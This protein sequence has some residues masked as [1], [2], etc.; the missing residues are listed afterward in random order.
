MIEQ[1][2]IG[3]YNQI[4]QLGK[5]E[6]GS[7][8]SVGIRSTVQGSTAYWAERSHVLQPSYIRGFLSP[9]FQ[10]PDSLYTILYLLLRLM[11]NYRSKTD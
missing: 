11:L 10:L 9:A 8:W 5:A 6:D 3:R 2:P 4:Y 7:S 1:G